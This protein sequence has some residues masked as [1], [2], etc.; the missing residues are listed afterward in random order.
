MFLIGI[1]L[2]LILEE[3]AKLLIAGE[4]GSHCLKFTVEDIAQAFSDADFVQKMLL[5]TD[6]TSPV[7]GFEQNQT[8]F[9]NNMKAKGMLTDTTTNLKL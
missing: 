9:V 3:N 4:A 7:T 1:L 5:L 2:I 6:A 8:D